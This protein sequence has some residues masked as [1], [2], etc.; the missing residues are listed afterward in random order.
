M[1]KKYIFV[2]VFVLLFL[3]FPSG[4]NAFEAE[5][6]Y[7]ILLEQS[8]REVLFDNNAY[9]TAAPAS[10][11]KLMT[12]LITFEQ[13]EQGS[14]AL[15][16]ETV[17]SER[18]SGTGGTQLYLETGEKRTIEELILATLIESA[19]DAAVALSEAVGGSYDN[20]ISM[21]NSRGIDLGLKNSVFVNPTGLDEDGHYTC[22]YDIALIAAEL[23]EHE[24]ILDYS[25]VWMKDLYIGKNNDV[26]RTLVNTNKLIARNDMIDGLKTGF[27]ENAGCCICATA[28]KNGMRIISVVL[29]AP[30]A[31]TR[32][33]EAEDMLN[34]G[35]ACFELINICD[36]GSS[37][38]SV[39]IINASENS[40]NLIVKEKITYLCKKGEEPL[41]DKKI[42]LSTQTLSAP[43]E[44]NKKI[45]TIIFTINGEE[46]S[47]A[48]LYTDKAYEKLSIGGYIRKIK[49]LLSVF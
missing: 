22:A 27:T 44:E 33:S 17:I 43:V 40:A 3:F 20:F 11:T 5:S 34:Y 39:P 37:V 38:E 31:E 23:L 13:L 29:F 7:G 32:F 15:T 25:T 47:R 14:I 16:D 21:M 9:E 35:F 48:N 26:L 2:I 1:K 19:N 4:V 28:Q 46:Y 12:L 41:I 42:E 10:L 8:T 45:G 36:E 18:A 6:K 49:G 30:N 24:E